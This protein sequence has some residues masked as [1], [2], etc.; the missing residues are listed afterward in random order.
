MDLEF[1]LSTLRV[2]TPLL[3]AAIGGY[4][5]EKAGV[6]NIALEGFMLVGA[7][8]AA[9][10]TL[11]SG[12]PEIGFAAGAI[13]GFLYGSLYALFTVYFRTNQIVAGTAFNFLAMGAI[14]FAL[15]ILYDSTGASP[16]IPMENR[17]Q[18]FPLYFAFLL[19][20]L[21]FLQRKYLPSGLRLSVA[22]ENPEALEAAGFSV[23]RLRFFAVS[24]AGAIAALGGASLSIY[25]SSGYSRNMVAGRGFMALAALIFGRWRPLNAMLACL[26]FGALEASQIRLQSVQFGQEA[27]FAPQFIQILPYLVTMIILAGFIGKNRTP[28]ALGK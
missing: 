24:T 7:F 4:Y 25:L 1:F 14:P 11:M 27:L 16:S 23:K 18:S 21:C 17:F 5:S 10:F 20:A 19:A 2:S 12:S 22:G 28:K 26:L 6:V 13:G 3:F 9:I 8:C 15:K